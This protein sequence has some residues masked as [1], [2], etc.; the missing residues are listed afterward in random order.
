MNKTRLL[1]LLYPA[2]IPLH[3]RTIADSSVSVMKR[4]REEVGALGQ[5]SDDNFEIIYYG[6]RKDEWSVKAKAYEDLVK[7]YTSTDEVDETQWGIDL[8]IF[9]P[10]KSQDTYGE[11]YANVYI[12]NNKEDVVG[13]LCVS[14]VVDK[15]I[16][17]T[18]YYINTVNIKEDFQG[19]GLCTRLVSFL[20]EEFN[21]LRIDK[22]YIQ[23]ASSTS[24]GIPACFCY[25]KAGKKNG[26]K[27][28]YQTDYSNVLF[29]MNDDFCNTDSDTI[30]TTYFYFSKRIGNS[31]LNDLKRR[32]CR[33]Q[34]SSSALELC[35]AILPRRKQAA[36]TLLLF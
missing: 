18:A 22:V 3:K 11:P 10:E 24:E 16:P 12:I 26:Y 6:L 35:A 31:N 29:R 32:V 34:C 21:R 17:G 33:A 27:M 28:Y 14:K 19:K 36:Q 7:N 1:L 4:K 13:Y 20:L 9:F 5:A 30:L 25:Y 8:E 15:K 2:G 23:N